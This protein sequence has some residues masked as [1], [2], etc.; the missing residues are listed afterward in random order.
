LATL[1][2]EALDRV[3]PGA[4]L[5]QVD[6]EGDEKECF[7]ATAAITTSGIK[8][9]LQILAKGKTA[10]VH[11]TQLGDVRGDSCGRSPSEWQTEETFGRYLE[12]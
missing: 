7:T 12:P 8:L 2:L 4:T 10:R 11:A 6:I 9:P 5:V 3:H 1:S